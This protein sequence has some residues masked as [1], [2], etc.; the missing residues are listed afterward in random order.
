MAVWKAYRIS[1]IITEIAEEKFVLPVIQ[2][3]LVWTE[4]KIELL[5]DTLLKGDS[6]GG[7]MV[8]EEEKD[9]KPL[10][11][12]RP[13]TKD[14]SLIA[15]RQVNILTQPQSFVIDGQQRLQA[16][17]LGLSGS[18]NG[19]V[20]YFDLYSDYKTEFEFK[21]ENDAKN[22]PGKSKDNSDRGIPEHNWY[23]VSGLL[24]RLKDTNDE[25][26][27]S[28]EIISLQGIFDDARKTHI[29]KNVKAFYKN[30]IVSETLG[31]S[32]VA[33]NRSFDDMA[34]RQR[35]VEL[36][37]RL[38]D[39]GTKL[40]PFDLV[41][42][43]LKGFAW[44]MEGFLRETLEMYE[45]IG[46]SQDNL[47]KL[48]FILQDNH[49]KEISSIE[50]AD[51]KFAID[52]RERITNTLKSL[53]D[54][55]IHAKV[56]DYY[57]DG[58]R[59]FVP[60]HFIAYQIYHQEIDNNSVLSYFNNYDTG[61]TDFV[62]IKEW[63]F[64]SLL[65]GVFRSKG[66]GWIPYKTGVKKILEEIKNHKGKSFPIEELIKVYTNH[67]IAFTTEYNTDDL[68]K[69]DSSFVYYLMY[70][71]AK[72]IRI[73]DIDHIMPKSILN[74]HQYDPL[75]INSIKNFQLIDPGTNRGAKNGKSFDC[76]I[77]NPE[78]VTD[79]PA[80][81]KLHLIPP[82]AAIWTE[83]KFEDFIEARANLILA[84]LEEHTA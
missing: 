38:N 19:K 78:Y 80:F 52:N 77:N 81:L 13:F 17:Y 10:F 15:A 32:K 68:D 64:H 47:I 34:N 14:G 61:N 1:E 48:I 3:A 76:W 59:S 39:G 8:I 26:Q 56:Y 12:F 66:A 54:F 55:L 72:T 62:K 51:A 82:N 57:K 7:I 20:L 63:L 84:K 71:K 9:S 28:S 35:I 31:I 37:R 79:Q 46:L 25:D 69:L 33:L 74:S 24:K 36:F 50:E 6:F 44:E 4:D 83:D 43:V 41:A 18:I 49:N 21:F 30:I 5:F 70:D 65:N 45:E 16:F 40:S 23:L 42:S 67:P 27:V 58:N 60:L 22:L 75:K 53:K 2:R 73:N 29:T 11:S